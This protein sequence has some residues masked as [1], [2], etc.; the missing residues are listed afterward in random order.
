MN[1]QE[2]ESNDLDLE[3]LSNEVDGLEK[4]AREMETISFINNVDSGLSLTNEKLSDKRKRPQRPK[5]GGKRRKKQA[6][7]NK[8][9]MI[10][11]ASRD[12]GPGSASSITLC[13]LMNI[14]DNIP[15]GS[16]GIED[17]TR[18]LPFA[19]SLRSELVVEA[20][21]SRLAHTATGSE[22]GLQHVNTDKTA[23]MENSQER[24]HLHR[25][26]DF[27]QGIPV[28]SAEMANYSRLVN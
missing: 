16:N 4:L 18:D 11:S 3:E 27:S 26:M 1:F 6:K 24:K 14:C 8:N 25:E 9:Q 13:Q 2:T 17:K 5:S 21:G 7:R 15:M 12:S 20:P 22:T 19:S 28:R 10:K 23:R